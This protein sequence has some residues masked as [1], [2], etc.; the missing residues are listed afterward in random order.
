M[1]LIKKYLGKVHGYIIKKN[2]EFC[3]IKKKHIFDRVDHDR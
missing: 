1:M 3:N 2:H